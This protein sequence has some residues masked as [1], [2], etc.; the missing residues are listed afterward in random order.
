M[1]F[2]D[3]I[4]PKALPQHIG[5][6]MDGN[7]RWALE[8]RLP[9]IHGHR[10][11]VNAV[12]A[13]VEASAELGLNVLTLFAFSTENWQRPEKE[14][15]ALMELFYEFLEKELH[16]MLENNVR[17][18]LIG[19]RDKLPSFLQDRLSNALNSTSENSGLLLNLALNYGGRDEIS[20]AMRKLSE[21]VKNGELQ[22]E[23]IDEALISA[24]TYTAGLPDPDL[25]IRTSGELRLSNFLIWQAAYAEFYFTE[26][27]W[28]DFD[29][30]D[31]HKAILDYQHRKR[32]MGR[33]TASS[34]ISKSKKHLSRLV[35]DK[36][37]KSSLLKL[38]LE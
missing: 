2:L 32:R 19:D 31:L 1:S 37:K 29:K 11:A 28:P 20:R 9:R 6:I 17:F 22:P 12:R 25:I 4:D 24:N 34:V 7:G 21:L 18:Q 36:S 14:V 30:E 3:K 23:N 16:T 38:Q 15:S 13:S 5:I 26:V 27:L 10:S 33:T 8:R 35:S